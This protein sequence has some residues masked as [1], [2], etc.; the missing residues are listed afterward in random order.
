MVAFT[1]EY[2]SGHITIDGNEIPEAG[3][4]DAESLPKIPQAGTIAREMIDWF[5]QESASGIKK[6]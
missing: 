1:A 2:K 4:F 3:W 6:I 5:V